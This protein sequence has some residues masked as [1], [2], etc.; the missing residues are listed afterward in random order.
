[1]KARTQTLRL[2]I[3]GKEIDRIVERCDLKYF[4]FVGMLVDDFNI[5]KYNKKYAANNLQ[6]C[7]I[8]LSRESQHLPLHLRKTLYNT[9]FSQYMDCGV[10]T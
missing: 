2:G 3:G 9:L 8:D 10:I 5:W 7:N 4:K 1:M 6:L